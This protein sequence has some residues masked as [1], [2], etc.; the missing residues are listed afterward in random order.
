MKKKFLILVTGP[1]AIG[2]TAFSIKLAQYLNTEILSSDSRQFYREMKIGTAYPDAEE[3]SAVKHHFVGNL[4][5]H[6]EYNVSCYEREAL[7]LLDELFQGHDHVVLTGGSG[8]YIDALCKGIDELPDYDPDLRKKLKNDI[9]RHGLP[10]LANSLKELDPEYYELVDLQNP[11]RV[12]RAL[13]V[14]LQTGK[15]YSSL[16]KNAIK[17]RPFELISIGLNVE[18]EILFER[19]SRRVDGM[20]EKGLLEEVKSLIPYR[21]LNA[22]NTVGYKEIFS[23]LDGALSLDEA[24]E[25]IKTNTR[26]YAKRQLTWF[27]RDPEMKWFEPDDLSGV[28]HYLSEAGVVINK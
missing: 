28:I 8:L 10:Y 14:C 4:S 16:R 22:L 1:T 21:D 5:V 18:R 3:L 25:K 20:I 17:K 26:R 12:M 23:F 27:K 19:I 13:E 6:D 15:S 11:N 7:L 2:K 9:E 24:I